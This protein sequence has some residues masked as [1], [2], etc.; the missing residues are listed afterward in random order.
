MSIKLIAIDIDGTL[1]NSQHQLTPEVHEALKAA[2]DQGVRI[3]LCTGRPLKGVEALLK[4]IDLYSDNDYVITYNGSLVQK[5]KNEEVVSRFG[6]THDDYLEIDALARKLNVHLH[7]ETIDAIYTSNRDISPYSVL[8]S[9][10]TNMPLKYRTQEEITPAFNILKMMMIDDP[11]ILDAAIA[12]IP[13]EINEKFT[14]VKSTPYFLEFMHKEVDKGAAVKRL[15]EHLGIQREEIMALGDNEN[16]LTMI[17]YAGLGVAMANATENVKNAAD[18]MTT[19]NDEHGVAE[20][21]K[22]HVLN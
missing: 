7:T 6:L 2:E 19:S 10:L 12:K 18:A 4:E 1:L 14:V 15:G 22:K 16:D 3:V 21:I 9:N 11:E 8:E 20:A 17:Q 13:N 5:T